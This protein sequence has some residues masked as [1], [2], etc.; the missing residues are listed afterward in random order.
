MS[1]LISYLKVNSEGAGF[2]LK[3]KITAT[4]FV[5][6]KN[7]SVSRKLKPNPVV[8]LPMT[9][10][11][12]ITEDKEKRLSEIIAEIN[13]RSGGHFDNDD[14]IK[15]ILSIRDLMKKDPSLRASAKNN[16]LKDFEFPYYDNAEKAL[17]NVYSQHQ[18]LCTQLLNNNDELKAILG[19]FMPEIYKSLCDEYEKKDQ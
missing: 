16:N 11:L 19:I 15:I 1:Y 10:T 9:D 14:A 7:D 13:L 5:Q 8:K 17:L 2:S 18:E 6:K 4:N 3:D 12:A